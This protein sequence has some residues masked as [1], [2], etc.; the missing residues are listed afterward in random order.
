MKKWSLV[1][2]Y[3]AC[4]TIPL[5]LWFTQSFKYL[6]FFHD[7]PF[8]VQFSDLCDCI[9]LSIMV[10]SM[11]LPVSYF[12]RFLARFVMDAFLLGAASFVVVTYQTSQ[13]SEI[14]VEDTYNHELPLPIPCRSTIK[15]HLRRV[16]R[17]DND[18]CTVCLMPMEGCNQLRGLPNC[19]HVFH[20]TCIHAWID[21][22]GTTC[23]ICRSNIVKRTSMVKGGGRDPR[24][25][26]RMLYLFVQHCFI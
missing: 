15:E 17:Y 23:P 11:F 13:E 19:K 6:L 24:R 1:W 3:R 22:R 26:E 25:R 5:Y 14:H 2:I 12:P 18:D 16:L 4:T 7:I 21:R 9:Q 8:P 10:H 20:K